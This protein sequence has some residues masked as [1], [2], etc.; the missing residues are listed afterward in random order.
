MKQLFTLLFISTTL[1]GFAQ[2]EP[3]WF[4]EGST[5]TYNWN[6]VGDPEQLDNVYE[7]TVSEITTFLGK[8]VVK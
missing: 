3:I 8:A 2:D 1:T 6:S 7:Y 5:W 4:E